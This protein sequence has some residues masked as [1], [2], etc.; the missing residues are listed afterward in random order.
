M[1]ITCMLSLIWTANTFDLVFIMTRGGP[2][3]AT[4]VFTML[5][6][7]QGIRNGRI[8]EASTAAMMA[9]PVFAGL[10]VILTRYLQDKDE[11]RV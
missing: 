2:S 5:I 6:Y 7:E 4:E 3:N 9:M 10:I 11:E 8:G 1:L